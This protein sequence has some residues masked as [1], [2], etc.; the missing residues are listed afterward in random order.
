MAFIL[1]LS[2]CTSQQADCEQSNF[3]WGPGQTLPI[4]PTAQDPSFGNDMRDDAEQNR[5]QN[6]SILQ[7]F[8]GTLQNTLDSK[9]SHMCVKIDGI[10][11]RLELLETCQK[12]LEEEVRISASNSVSM[13]SSPA[14]STPGRKRQTPVALQVR[15][16]A[17][18]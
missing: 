5:S 11:N 8:F 7:R 13:N 15:M 14:S 1:S 4:Q 3:N 17:L 12:T 10:G 6:V 18:N 2:G 9:I 16:T